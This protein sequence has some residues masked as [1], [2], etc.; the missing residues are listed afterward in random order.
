VV[1]L[2]EAVSERP[3]DRTLAGLRWHSHDAYRLVSGQDGAGDRWAARCPLHPASDF[4]LVVVD[5]GDDREPSLWCK[6][7]CP[8]Q[9]ICY[10]LSF[11][12]ERDRVAAE[13]AEALVWAQNWR[14]A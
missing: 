1:Y 2:N 9:V 6:V 14:A 10:T 5:E 3:V 8:P 11:D 4:S 7:G 13:R 12:P